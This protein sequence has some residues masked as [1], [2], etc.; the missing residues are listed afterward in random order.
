MWSTISVDMSTPKP[1]SDGI[2]PVMSWPSTSN[3]MS[4]SSTSALIVNFLASFESSLG[5]KLILS[6]RGTRARH[7]GATASADAKELRRMAGVP[8]WQKDA[9]E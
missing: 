9:G 6:A 4:P 3:V 2:S 8:G 1:T 5:W 7:S